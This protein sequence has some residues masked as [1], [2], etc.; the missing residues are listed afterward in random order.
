[1][2]LL[3]K[4]Q[5]HCCRCCRWGVQYACKVNQLVMAHCE[6]LNDSKLTGVCCVVCF[7]SMGA[8]FGAGVCFSL[9]SGVPNPLQSAF[10]TGAAFAGFNGLFYQVRSQQRQ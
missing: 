1:V 8:A 4:N 2:G 9:V 3:S 5:L 10:T 7:Y 6:H